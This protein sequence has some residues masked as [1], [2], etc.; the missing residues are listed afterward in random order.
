MSNS[1]L[2]PVQSRPTVDFLAA[3]GAASAPFTPPFVGGTVQNLPG[4]PPVNSRRWILRVIEYLASSDFGLEFD[5]FATAAGL[6][7]SAATDTFVSRY[8][9]AAANGVQFNGT[10]PFR[11]YSDGLAIPIVDLDS[12]NTVNPPLLHVAA[13]NIDTVAKAAS[14]TDIL[15]VTFWVEPMQAW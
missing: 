7:A 1:F 4:L 15:Q 3:L 14:P 9:F 5:F 2:F 11:F 8:Q 13:Q 6:T 10:G 12:V